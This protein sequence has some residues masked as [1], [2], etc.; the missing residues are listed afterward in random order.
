MMIKRC[1]HNRVDEDGFCRKC[2]ADC[3]AGENTV[4]PDPAKEARL[5]RTPQDYA[6]EHGGYLATAAESYMN[7]VQEFAKNEELGDGGDPDIVSDCFR[8]LKD[9][10]YEFRKRAEKAMRN[11]EAKP[12]NTQ[13]GS[14]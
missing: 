13:R 9:A 5:E 3:R 6:I 11:A 10:I 2:G 7:A 4:A 12:A 14:W 1:K 8:G